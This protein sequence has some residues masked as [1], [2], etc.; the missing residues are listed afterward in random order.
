MWQ[1]QTFNWNPNAP[2]GVLR[3]IVENIIDDWKQT[4][5]TAF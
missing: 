4:L 5:V 2:F 3:N 1:Q